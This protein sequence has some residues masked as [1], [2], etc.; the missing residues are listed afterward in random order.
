M[1]QYVVLLF[2][3]IEDR[4][5]LSFKD[6]GNV[7]PGIF[8]RMLNSLKK[9]FDI[10]GLDYL[11]RGISGKEKRSGRLCAITFDDGPKSYASRAV[12]LMESMGIPSTCFLITDCIGDKTTYWRYLYNFCMQSGLGNQLGALIRAEYGVSVP[13]ETIMSFT[14]NNFTRARHERVLEGIFTHLVA[15]GRY[16]EEERELFLSEED[17]AL[18]KGNPLV[19]FGIHTRTHPVLRHLRG[20]EITD[21]LSGSIDFYRERIRDETPMFSIPFG[22][23]QKD[24][25]ERTIFAAR[26]LSIKVILSA[27]GGGNRLGQPLYNIRRIPVSEK[28]W[29][30]GA[31]RFRDMIGRRCEA[32]EY[33]GAEKRLYE[34]IEGDAKHFNSPSKE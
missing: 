5:L 23:L 15:E 16:R 20:G 18:L 13:K 31:A 4:D 27:Y 2:H 9:D 7:R 21:E 28:M 19:S 26:D 22:R 8:E 34:I 30:K 33:A 25:D 14:R 10:V 24:Y 11:I 29:K 17:I 12:P 32:E 3:S 6:L 1:N